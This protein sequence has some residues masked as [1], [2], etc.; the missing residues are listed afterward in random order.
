MAAIA[1]A[2]ACYLR[3]QGKELRPPIAMNGVQYQV[4]IEDLSCYPIAVAVNGD[5]W[6]AKVCG[7]EPPVTSQITQRL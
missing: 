3:E 2:L 5:R 1:L 7:E 4:E 6:W